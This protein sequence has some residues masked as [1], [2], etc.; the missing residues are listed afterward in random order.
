MD[1]LKTGNN[2]V[3]LQIGVCGEMNGRRRTAVQGT[4][5]SVHMAG[6]GGWCMSVILDHRRL[7]LGEVKTPRCVPA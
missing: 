1:D 3:G 7:L 4:I 2:A 5:L 6:T